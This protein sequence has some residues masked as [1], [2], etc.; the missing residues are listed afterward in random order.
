MV[1]RGPMEKKPHPRQEYA[2][3]PVRLVPFEGME[4]FLG[5]DDEWWME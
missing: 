4:K 2:Y 5:D 1:G 3:D